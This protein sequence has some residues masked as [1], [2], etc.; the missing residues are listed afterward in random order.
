[1][2]DLP[3]DEKSPPEELHRA[4]YWPN[5]PGKA[6]LDKSKAPAG[7]RGDSQLKRSPTTIGFV[8]RADRSDAQICAYGEECYPYPYL[9]KDMYEWYKDA[10][11]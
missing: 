7:K 9:I 6:Q 10:A 4:E 1:M 2:Q 3:D 8:K 5:G 11:W